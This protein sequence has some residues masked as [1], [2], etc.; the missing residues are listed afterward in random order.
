MSLLDTMKTYS[1]EQ[2]LAFIKTITL[3]ARCSVMD[4]E[5]SAAE[6]ALPPNMMISRETGLLVG[7]A[8]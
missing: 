7:A 2:I 1:T 4:E 6:E 5:I 8:K 3:S